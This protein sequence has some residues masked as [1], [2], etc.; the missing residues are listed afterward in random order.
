MDQK[1]LK[2]P[3][4]ELLAR[5][6]EVK[7]LAMDVDGVLT[8]GEIIVLESGEEVKFFNSKDRLG[9]AAL[10]DA[11]IPLHI[12]WITG[13]SS[14][15]VTLAAKDL[16]V[17]DVVMKSSDKRGALEAILS[18][19]KLSFKEAAFIGDD[20]ID[21]GVLRAVG[22]SACPSDATDDIRAQVH[23]VSP[24]AGGRGV[25]RDV[26]EFILKAQGRWDGVVSSFL[27]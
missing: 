6:R 11:K 8:G 27:R 9:I 20:L 17:G 3:E 26:L 4:A 10:R 15:G 18:K 22:F 25:A 14:K 1:R 13:R 5:A 21:L 24:L 7:L 2:I 23:Y 19:H 16:G 12:A